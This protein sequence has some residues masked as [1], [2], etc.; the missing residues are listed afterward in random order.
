M[1]HSQLTHTRREFLRDAYCGFGGLAL[2]S[3]LQQER[4]AADPL[5]PKTPPLPAKAKAVIFLF[6]AGGPSHIETFDP[7]P[8]LNQLHGQQRPASF[9]PARYQF[10]RPDARLM[11]TT[12]KFTKYGQSGIEVSNLFPHTARHIDDIA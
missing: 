7:K 10:I 5:G 1:G 12:R 9:G 3:L 8:L 4:A 6:M 2:A 11:G